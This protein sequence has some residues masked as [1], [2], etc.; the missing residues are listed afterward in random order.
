MLVRAVGYRGTALP[1]L[2]FDETTGTIPNA[3]G[4]VLRDG[5]ATPG[6]YVAGW[7]KRGPTGVMAP[8]GAKRTRRWTLC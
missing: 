3:S 7:T 5:A 6:E 2:P 4:R 1:G 8:T